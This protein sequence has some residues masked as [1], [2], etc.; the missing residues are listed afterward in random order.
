MGVFTETAP[1]TCRFTTSV[2]NTVE[3]ETTERGRFVWLRNIMVSVK[4]SRL[5]KEYGAFIV[6]YHHGYYNNKW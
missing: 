3:R 4:M 6:F 2:K 1:P 5:V